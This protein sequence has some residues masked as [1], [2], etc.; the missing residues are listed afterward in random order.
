[1]SYTTA[2]EFGRQ[3]L[4]AD[5]QVLFQLIPCGICGGQNDTDLMFFTSTLE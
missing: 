4:N 3:I 1:M 2:L 5:V